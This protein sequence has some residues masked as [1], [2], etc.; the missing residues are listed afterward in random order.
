MN[1]IQGWCVS[2]RGTPVGRWTRK[3]PLGIVVGNNIYDYCNADPIN[4][5]DPSGLE[6]GFTSPED[7]ALAAYSRFGQISRDEHREYGGFIYSYEKFGKS[8]YGF[9]DAVPPPDGY[10]ITPDYGALLGH[11]KCFGDKDK[12]R[13]TFKK[14]FGKDKNLLGYYHTHVY[15]ENYTNEGFS[16]PDI[17]EARR[18]GLT[19]FVLDVYGNA[20]RWH[21]N[22][23]P[24][25]IGGVKLTGEMQTNVKPSLYEPR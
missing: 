16:K 6:E 2:G 13:K 18:L 5:T 4:F 23:Y 17:D 7:A 1:R 3:D 8:W 15:F 12:L 9:T 25:R 21:E 19:A 20:Y 11:E 22:S 10:N 14:Y 24:A